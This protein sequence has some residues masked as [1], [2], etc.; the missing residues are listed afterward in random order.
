MSGFRGT[1]R[2]PESNAQTPVVDSLS[3][4]AISLVIRILPRMFESA[5]SAITTLALTDADSLR[6][7][8]MRLIRLRPIHFWGCL[9]ISK[10]NLS[11]SPIPPWVQ[12]S[13]LGQEYI[14]YL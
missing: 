1:G 3:S 12:Y 11:A 9:T 10:A 14:Q 13:S 2:S 7:V 6:A 8:R 5:A 4:E